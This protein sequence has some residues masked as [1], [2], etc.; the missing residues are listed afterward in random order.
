M[1]TKVED[2]DY[3]SLDEN[4]IENNTEINKDTSNINKNIVE[5]R[6]EVEKQGPDNKEDHKHQEK[7]V[8][9]KDHEKIQSQGKSKVE[10][11]GDFYNKSSIGIADTH[12]KNIENI[13]RQATETE[14]HGGV[15]DGHHT[16][17]IN[18]QNQGISEKNE[19]IESPT[20]QH[21]S[22]MQVLKENFDK[23]SIGLSKTLD[24]NIEE[25]QKQATETSRRGNITDSQFVID[26]KVK[27]RTPDVLSRSLT[28]VRNN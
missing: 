2:N 12:D 26:S 22:K 15:I 3:N 17:G 13:Q 24:K 4:I 19:E 25:I 21:K 10:Q 8:I 16:G 18:T 11:L 14:G 7:G 20:S 5:P 1:I 23:N 27:A 9:K 28:P 6:V